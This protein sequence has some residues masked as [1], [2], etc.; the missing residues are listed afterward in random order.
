MSR[1]E[2]TD[3]N[4][5]KAQKM[6]FLFGSLSDEE[7]LYGDDDRLREYVGMY[8]DI[9]CKKPIE[10]NT[11]DELRSAAFQLTK[12]TNIPHLA[13]EKTSGESKLFLLKFKL[14]NITENDRDELIRQGREMIEQ[15]P[16]I[17]EYSQV[18][19]DFY[20]L[21]DK[22]GLVEE[23]PERNN[24]QEE[25]LEVRDIEE[26]YDSIMARAREKGSCFP[27]LAEYICG[28]IQGGT[29]DLEGSLETGI[30]Q[31]TGIENHFQIKLTYLFGR[32][33]ENYVQMPRDK[34]IGVKEMKDYAIERG[35]KDLREVLG[36]KVFVY[37]E[38]GV[39]RSGRFPKRSFP[40]TIL[41]IMDR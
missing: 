18:A 25:N 12:R 7:I 34:K 11:V 3:E 22:F 27:D 17:T 15:D 5:M 37:D 13:S 9:Y 26:R 35:V 8:F 19:K 28:R 36:M 4:I 10:D 16:T 41:Q 32:G 38:D 33:F 29:N 30:P 24:P 21:V 1:F 6:N 40:K 20:D 31:S 39:D 2:E 14:R 23:R